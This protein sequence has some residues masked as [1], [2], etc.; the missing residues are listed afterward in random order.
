MNV[1]FVD[2]NVLIYAHDADMG[3]KQVQAIELVDRLAGDATGAISV[4]VLVEFYSAATKKLHMTSRDS[5]DVIE[6]LICSMAIHRPEPSDVL[7]AIG[8]Q[9]RYKTSWFD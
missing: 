1:E 7:R 4:Q 2:T 9:R 3:S 5:A 8:L 6:D